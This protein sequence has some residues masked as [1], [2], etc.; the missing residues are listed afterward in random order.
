MK[1]PSSLEIFKFAE[2]N[3]AQELHRSWR[4]NM[5]EQEREVSSERMEWDTLP[6]K[7]KQLD[8]RIANDLY[9]DFYTWLR[10]HSIANLEAQLLETQQALSEREDAFWVAT[11][12]ADKQL[13]EV[14]KINKELEAAQN[15]IQTLLELE[16]KALK[17]ETAH[18][19]RIEELSKIIIATAFRIGGETKGR[20]WLIAKGI[21]KKVDEEQED[22]SN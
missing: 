9:Q 14:N 2:S 19:A 6:R 11:R 17:R 13:G 16:G 12:E 18:E 21:I 10:G 8:L 3:G 7:D 4:D 20:K 5:L 15:N 22:E 1:L